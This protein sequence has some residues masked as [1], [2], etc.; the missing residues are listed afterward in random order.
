MAMWYSEEILLDLKE[1]KE[2]IKH[3]E[4]SDELAGVIVNVCLS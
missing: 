3:I 2:L 4:C 1:K